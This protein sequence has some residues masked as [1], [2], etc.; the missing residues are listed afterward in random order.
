M[1]QDVLTLALHVVD[2]AVQA[3]E[4]QGLAPGA[5][6]A[7]L[8]SAATATL[9]HHFEWDRASLIQATAELTAPSDTAFNAE[10]PRDAPMQPKA[11]YRAGLM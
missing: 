5:M 9:A 11:N 3:E 8:F 1:P 7:A 6:V 2:L 10:P 4:E